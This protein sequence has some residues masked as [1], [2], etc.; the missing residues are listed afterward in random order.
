MDKVINETLYPTILIRAG[1]LI[2]ITIK[3]NIPP[4]ILRGLQMCRQNGIQCIP[5]DDIK[6]PNFTNTKWTTENITTKDVR[7]S[8]LRD[9]LITQDLEHVRIKFNFSEADMQ[10]VPQNPFKTCNQN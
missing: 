7:T 4:Q 8:L 6:L 1:I 2:R 3:D 9:D 10:S 5:G